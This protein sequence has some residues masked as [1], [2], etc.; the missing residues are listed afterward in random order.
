MKT[1]I[2]TAIGRMP[3]LG[4]RCPRRECG[5]QMQQTAREHAILWQ[6]PEG[7]YSATETN[8]G[9]RADFMNALKFQY[10]AAAVKATRR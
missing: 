7:H 2:K 10:S 5:A 1:A 3:S 8:A 9:M 4:S 6:C